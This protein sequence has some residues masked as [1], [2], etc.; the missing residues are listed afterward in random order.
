M[1]NVFRGE[2]VSSRIKKTRYWCRIFLLKH[3]RT[4]LNIKKLHKQIVCQNVQKKKKEEQSRKG[5]CL[6]NASKFY[7]VGNLKKINF[8]PNYCD[9]FKTAFVEHN[10]IFCWTLSNVWHRYSGLDKY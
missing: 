5:V 2:A 4:V 8:T 3:I 9:R 7:N 1:Q 10:S 6:P